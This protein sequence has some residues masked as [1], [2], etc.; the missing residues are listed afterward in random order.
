MGVVKA[1]FAAGV[2]AVAASTTVSAA[3]LLPP[4]PPL[5]GP[6]A[7]VAP[8]YSGWYLRG[9]VGV[10][11][12]FSA[13]ASSTFAPGLTPPGFRFHQSEV[14]D[15]AF[16]GFGIGYRYNSWLRFD[17][18]GEYRGSASYHA[19]NSYGTTDAN[20][21]CSVGP[22]CFDVYRGTVKGGVVMGNAYVDLG[23]WGGITPYVGVGLGGAMN[24][25][26]NYYDFNPSTGGFGIGATRTKYQFAWALMAGLSYAVTQNVSLELGYRYLDRGDGATRLRCFQGGA[27]AGEQQHF[28]MGSHDVRVGMRWMFANDVSYASPEPLVRKY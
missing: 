9:D 13:D 28:R 21:T 11:S 26:S 23:T 20:N 16:V 12:A 22:T 3:D 27:C 4:P 5:S 18:T 24:R 19:I 10:G 7:H 2:L 17:V 14:G 6:A 1:L 25:M 8:D 15:A